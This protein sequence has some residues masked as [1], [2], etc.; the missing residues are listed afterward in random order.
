MGWRIAGG[1]VLQDGTLDPG[2]LHLAGG[3]IAKAGGGRSF[4]A[5]GLLV[6][7]GLIDI[8]GDAHERS[9]QPRP[10]IGFP[11]G[12]AVR[13]AASQLLGLGI[14]TAY[15]GVTLSWEP[16]LR[17]LEAW[18]GLMAA[19]DAAK[20]AIDLRVHLRFEADNLDALPDALADIAAGR[21][22][23]IGF[24][25]H[26]PAILKKLGNPKEVA[27]YAGRAGLT[28][29]A[30]RTL[31]E[32]VAAKR[33]EVPA[34]RRKLAEA[35]A[36]RGLPMLSHDD[37]TLED[38]ALF[39]GLGARICEFPM[40]E[41]VAAD[42]RA[43]GEHVVM[44]APNVVRG[45]SHL[46]WAS[47]APLAERGLVTVLA[48]DYH[49]PALLEAPFAMARR[50]KMSL[51]AAWDLVS[52]NPAAAAELS[53]RGRLA[54]GLRGDVVVIDPAGPHVVAVFCG[55]ELA[56]LGAGGARRLG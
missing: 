56:H 18:R 48:S 14:T 27:K 45:G 32:G 19:L 6:M 29:E 28:P 11:M 21:V 37:A 40:A 44:G 2:E 23:L 25:D 43:A 10:G 24:N 42:A 7:P 3:V 33:G 15:M 13:D 49:W 54:E 22:H 20:P 52:A 39:R 51:A 17:S 9:I 46:G 41:E 30:F 1:Q 53:D 35:A 47:A 55:G 34:T 38:R 12:F 26:T 31:I 36:A 50:G 8:H 5:T 4:D 16:G